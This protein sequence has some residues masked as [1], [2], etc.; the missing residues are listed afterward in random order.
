M[1]FK[2]VIKNN[3]LLKITSLNA[4]VIVFRLIISL[5][6]QR[7]LA[8]MVGEAGIAKIGQL[9]N[10]IQIITSS[11]TLG[12]FNGVIKYVSEYKENKEKIDGLFSSIFGFLFIG[13]VI[14]SGVLYYNVT[15]ITTE[16]FGD[17]EF[18]DVIRCLTLLPLIIG[19]NRVFYGIVNGL[20]EYKTFAKID[21]FSNVLSALLLVICLYQFNLKGVLFAI[22]IAPIIQLVIILYVFGATLNKYFKLKSLDFK[23]PFAKELL[24][25]TLMSIISTV[26]LNY[27]ELDLRIIITDKINIDEAGYWTAMNFIS[28]NYMA[29]SSSLFTLY[30]IPKFARIHTLP[31]FKKEVIN[32]YKT[33]LPLFGIGMLLVY[34]FRRVFIELIYP[35]FT[36]LEPLFKW[37]LLGDFVRLAALV[38]SHQF[39]AKKMVGSFVVTELISLGVFYFLSKNLVVLYGAEGVVMAHFYRCLIYFIIIICTIWFYFFK[40]EKKKTS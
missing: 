21:L 4:I 20:T 29:F 12:T 40:L 19:L 2:S 35:D 9:R 24:A 17:L 22:I 14:T 13:S 33:I 15:F 27:I 5:F 37:Q 26:L 10:L 8:I 11:S 31:L 1:N 32:I 28:K 39:L 36:G 23:I 16:L 6:I 3:L 38:I 30:V 7:L 18:V 34:L 25:F